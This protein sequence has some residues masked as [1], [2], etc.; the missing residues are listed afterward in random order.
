[1]MSRILCWGSIAVAL[2]FVVVACTQGGPRGGTSVS[3]LKEPRK[4]E[5]QWLGIDWTL[6]E[7]LI[8][9]TGSM[10]VAVEPN[11]ENELRVGFYEAEVGGSGP[12]WRASGWMAVVMSSLLLGIDI[13]SYKFTIDVS[14]QI[15]GPS[16]GALMTVTIISLLLNHTVKP[17]ASITGTI[18]PDGT[19]GPVGAI[20]QK[21]EGAAKAGK[22]LVLI[23]LGQRYNK[24]WKT[25]LSIDAVERGRQVGVEV[26]EVG[27]I[28]EAY[29]ALTGKKLPK[30]QG[31]TDQS[32][33]LPSAAFEK[34][35]AKAKEWGSRYEQERG[36][37]TGFEERY[38]QPFLN[39]HT[40]AVAADDKSDSFFGQGLV[41]G[42]YAKAQ[43]STLLMAL[44]AEG[45]RLRSI[46]EVPGQQAAQRQQAAQE[47]LNSVKSV[48]LMQIDGLI[49]RLKVEKAT[50][51]TEAIVIV[52]AYRVLAV[53]LGLVQMANTVM[54]RE[55]RNDDERAQFLETAA[56]Y[57][58]I[59]KY[60]AQ[61]AS[62]ML[63]LGL[64]TGGAGPAPDLQQLERF[65][66]ILRQAAG[67]NLNYFETI[68]LN[69]LAR[70]RN[71]HPDVFKQGF[72]DI[73]YTYAV[74]TFDVFSW[75]KDRVGSS[76]P[77]AYATL[78]AA[79]A[80]YQFSAALVAKYYSL[81]FRVDP[82]TN[83]VSVTSE[84]AL[85]HMLDFA[86]KRTRELISLA[87]Q[88]DSNL[89]QPILYFEEA[90]I[91][92]EGEVLE[93]LD[94]LKGFWIASLEAELM[95]IFAGKFKLAQ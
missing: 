72:G 84:R 75:L 65:G 83:A 10:R 8:G 51:A 92:R 82:N 39:L 14:G 35:K 70:D 74:A 77:V 91:S 2:L 59:A 55:P 67:A 37:F 40:Q 27:D 60:A 20:I 26:R 73:D 41:A 7:G 86:E 47:R 58:T 32:P 33:S 19:I 71:V 54:E 94:C 76:E 21:I 28:Y 89:V 23:P 61:V 29:E 42:S 4:A 69:Q 16:A 12:M 87:Q 68:V 11:S 46:L 22:K 1:M 5:V 57:C 34:V 66:K 45:T 50:N 13:I 44:A 93:K 36:A 78:G 88:V 6:R 53:A 3:P 24:D 18:N 80:S 95:T 30:P 15:D 49:D 56:R 52:D 85:I 25:Q 63:E 81:D 79:L 38:R 31:I 17:D 48:A 9:K 43:E 62:D 64:R 90:K